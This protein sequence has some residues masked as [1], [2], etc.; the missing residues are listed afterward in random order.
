M[1][2]ALA[3]SNENVSTAGTSVFSSGVFCRGGGGGGMKASNASGVAAAVASEDFGDL[4]VR[5]VFL[6]FVS[7]SS[8]AA[9]RLSDLADDDEAVVGLSFPATGVDR[10]DRVTERVT[11]MINDASLMQRVRTNTAHSAQVSELRHNS[12]LSKCRSHPFRVGRA[13]PRT[14]VLSNF[15]LSSRSARLCQLWRLVPWNIPC[16]YHQRQIHP[17]FSHGSFSSTTYDKK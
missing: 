17:F 4:F 10:V 11:G 2:C 7:S 6:G 16:S 8:S 14:L 15:S 9:F 5:G 12:L 3:S 1:R 13:T